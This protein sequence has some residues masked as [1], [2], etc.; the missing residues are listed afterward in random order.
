MKRNRVIGACHGFCARAGL[1][2][3]KWKGLVVAA[4]LGVVVRDDVAARCC[5]V[6]VETRGA[7]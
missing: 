1:G 5:L 4:E 3:W 7:R 2:A 6:L